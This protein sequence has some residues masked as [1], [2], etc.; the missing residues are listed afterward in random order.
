M[1]EEPKITLE[2]LK[3]ERAYL[4]VYETRFKNEINKTPID[5]ELVARLGER[6]AVSKRRIKEYEKVLDIK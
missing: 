4:R 6:V 2:L 5:Y 3:I 1:R